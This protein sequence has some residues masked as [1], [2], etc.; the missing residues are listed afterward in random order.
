M[1][2]RLSGV[3]C[4]CFREDGCVCVFSLC[5]WHDFICFVLEQNEKGR[6]CRDG[7]LMYMGSVCSLCMC[8]LCG[9]WGGSRQDQIQKPDWR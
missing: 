8:V 6:R 2:V 9:G 4:G 5:M 3:G 7:V 1:C